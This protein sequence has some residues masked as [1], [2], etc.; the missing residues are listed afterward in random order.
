[1]HSD[2]QEQ[3]GV[4]SAR[5]D[6]P[7]PIVRRPVAELVVIA[8]GAPQ[9]GDLVLALAAMEQFDR[10]ARARQA[11]DQAAEQLCSSCVGA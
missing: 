10:E 11:L 9:C 6:A 5:R 3:Q 1:M 8:A 7:Q 4:Q 2:I